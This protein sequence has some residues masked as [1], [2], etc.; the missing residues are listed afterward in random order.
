LN[1]KSKDRRYITKSLCP[2]NSKAIALHSQSD[3]LEDKVYLD[4][5]AIAPHDQGDCFEDKACLTKARQ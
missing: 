5:K 4:G 1:I 2:H 3:H